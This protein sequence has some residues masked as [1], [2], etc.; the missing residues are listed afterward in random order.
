MCTCVYMCVYALVSTH[1]SL[2][3]IGSVVLKMAM[4]FNGTLF[5]VIAENIKVS[6]MWN[7]SVMLSIGGVVS[8]HGVWGVFPL[9]LGL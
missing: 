6:L 7:V 4:A 8:F 3:D 9:P 2:T 5:P 1:H